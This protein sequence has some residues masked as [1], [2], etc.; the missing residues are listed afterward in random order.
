[1]L[2]KSPSRSGSLLVLPE[3]DELL[4]AGHDL[5]LAKR[6]FGDVLMGKDRESIM[7]D[8]IEHDRADLERVH[9]CAMPWTYQC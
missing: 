8:R 3:V 7:P 9:T 2:E 1:M 6:R 4:L 5:R